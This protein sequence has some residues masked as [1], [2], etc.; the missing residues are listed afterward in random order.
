VAATAVWLQVPLCPTTR[1]R[2]VTA[3]HRQ[4]I[5]IPQVE[6]LAGGMQQ[7]YRRPKLMVR[8]R[9]P[10]PAPTVSALPT[11]MISFVCAR[12]LWFP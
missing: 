9:F 6:E 11:G 2:V 12:P 5:K 7:R 3:A 4:T 10:S 8:V 1:P